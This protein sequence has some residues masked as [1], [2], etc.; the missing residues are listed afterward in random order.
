M[1]VTDVANGALVLEDG[2]LFFGQLRGATPADAAAGEVVF[3]TG[4]TGYPEIITDPSYC[5]QI[6]TLTAPHIG[7]V[8][9]PAGDDES[10]GAQVAGLIV[11]KLCRTR[12]GARASIDL[13]EYLRQQGIR[14]LEGIDTRAL[15]RHLR[16]QGAV[17]G[18]IT[19]LPENRTNL[20]AWLRETLGEVK[21]QDAMVGAELVSRVGARDLR[22]L[23]AY[24]G[25]GRGHIALLDMG[26]KLS[27]AEELRQRGC[28]IS[29]VPHDASLEDI[30]ALKPDA[31]MLS[32]GPGDPAA[33][34]HP[35]GV[36]RQ[37]LGKM[38][39][40]G[41]CLGHQ[42]LALAAGAKSY[43]LPFGHHGANHPVQDVS[44]GSV[45]ITS[46]NHGFSIDESSLRGTSFNVSHRSLYDGT[47]EG[48]RSLGLRAMSVQY[49]PEAA[50]GP[51]DALAIFDEFLR[52]WGRRNAA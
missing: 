42:I 37:L 32:N 12:S 11:R 35:I 9:M 6:V 34:L 13:E 7:N 21:K 52:Q 38:P 41:I 5:G 43:K 17:R 15:T 19:P 31:L 8:G 47:V 49:H 1:T 22:H 29:I 28:D 26:S 20:R 50:P 36:V 30:L 24:G 33:C 27:I 23:P 39:I 45:A 18:R 3:H 10:G 44:T 40:V 4:M 2:R 48:I 16:I 14:C 46:Q 25:G 51:H